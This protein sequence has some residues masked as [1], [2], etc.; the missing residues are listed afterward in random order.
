MSKETESIGRATMTEDGTI[1]LD[2]RA[3]SPQGQVGIGR[4]SY[5]PSHPQY[6]EILKHIG[7]IKPGENKP[8]P[9]WE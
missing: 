6:Q 1:V 7:G 4:L 9:P 5:P 8:V 2:L 3:V